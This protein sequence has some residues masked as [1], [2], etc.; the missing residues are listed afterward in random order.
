MISHGGGGNEVDWS[1]QGALGPI[2]DNLI[3]A[4]KIQPAVIVRPTS[5]GSGGNPGYRATCSTA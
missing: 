2:I 1:T 3:A 5:T 4:G